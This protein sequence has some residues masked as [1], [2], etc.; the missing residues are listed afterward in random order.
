MLVCSIDG[1]QDT[2]M[3]NVR[4]SF[5]SGLGGFLKFVFYFEICLIFKFEIVQSQKC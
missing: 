3:V 5:F 2:Y 4:S 1:D